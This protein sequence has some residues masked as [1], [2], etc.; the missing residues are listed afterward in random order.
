MPNI[1]QITVESAAE[2]LNAGAF[3]TGALIQIQTA[4]SEAGA[5][6]D[7]T[8]TGSTPTI[9]LVSGTRIYTGFDP[10]GASSAWYKTRYKNSGGTRLSDWS[11]AFQ[12]GD[13]TAGL[14]CS[15]YDVLQELGQASGNDDE[16]IIE[17]IRQVSRQIEHY[18]GRWFA[19]RPLSGTAT[20]RFHTEAGNVLHVPRGIRSITTLGYATED[21]PDSGGTYTL[22]TSTDYY[23]DPPL[24][25][26]TDAGDP[27]HWI[28][29]R[30]NGSSSFSDASFG[31]EIVGAFGYASVPYDIQ[32]VALRAAIRRYLGKA[33]GG[34]VVA[35]GPSGTEMLLPDMSGADRLTLQAYRRG[36]I[37]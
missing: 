5:F 15:L 18:C 27:G 22:A 9:A 26:R 4:T 25:D 8:G 20:Y 36:Y 3:D 30:W 34:A 28:R 29:L 1:L 7:L 23:I 10:S 2:L 31:A 21:Q 32:G 19:P 16:T 37:G 17:K 14:L 12:V 35:T 33:G 13:E 24:S 11:A 6:A